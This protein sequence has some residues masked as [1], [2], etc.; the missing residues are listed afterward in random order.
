MTTL[1][2]RAASQ[3]SSR[4]R[5]RCQPPSP[6]V[7]LTSVGYRENKSDAI[8][9]MTSLAGKKSMLTLIFVI[10]WGYFLYKGWVF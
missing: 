7:Q 4:C 2:K 10:A 9:I 5:N 1:D 6:P 8:I 3:A